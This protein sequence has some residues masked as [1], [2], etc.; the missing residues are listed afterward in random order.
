[1]IYKIGYENFGNCEKVVNEKKIQEYNNIADL[2][3]LD[4]NLQSYI[5]E[6]LD[7]KGVITKEDILNWY[8]SDEDILTYCAEADSQE[9]FLRNCT[10]L[11]QLKEQF[12]ESN[13]IFIFRNYQYSPNVLLAKFIGFESEKAVKDYCIKNELNYSE[14]KGGQFSLYEFN[15][16]YF[17]HSDD[18][19]DLEDIS[20]IINADE[21][22]V[23]RLD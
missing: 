20:A 7:D 23:Y 14:F 5:F 1:M 10:T 22:V 18:D 16:C 6:T 2:V 9:E 15:N 11:E 19:F 21:I 17:K 3:D 8:N 12:I 4:Q 13:T